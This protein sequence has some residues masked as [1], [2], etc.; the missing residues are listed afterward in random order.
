V[1]SVSQPNRAVE[2]RKEHDM[3]FLSMLRSMGELRDS[4]WVSRPND[5]TNIGGE[6]FTVVPLSELQVGDNLF[7]NTKTISEAEQ[8]LVCDAINSL[9]AQEGVAPFHLMDSECKE[10]TIHDAGTIVQVWL[11]PT[12]S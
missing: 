3:D 8:V 2:A 5:P 12:L 1:Q 4:F 11:A 10:S 6:G 9:R 7:V